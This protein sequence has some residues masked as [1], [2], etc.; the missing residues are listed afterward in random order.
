MHNTC[1]YLK[2]CP[3]LIWIRSTSISDLHRLYTKLDWN[4]INPPWSYLHLWRF[5]H[6]AQLWSHDSIFA[7]R[8]YTILFLDI[9]SSWLWTLSAPHKCNN[10]FILVYSNDHA[11]HLPQTHAS[12]NECDCH[13]ITSFL[14]LIHFQSRSNPPTRGGLAWS[15]S[16]WHK[17]AD[18]KPCTS[19]NRS[20]L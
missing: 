19:T 13:V 1:H 9:P 15:R 20:E 3:H 6:K 2:V 4:W 11:R 8:W 18:A 7:T 12:I 10:T 16:D 17:S 14:V 5:V